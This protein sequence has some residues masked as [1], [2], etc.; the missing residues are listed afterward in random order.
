MIPSPMDVDAINSLASG[1][2][3]I[4]S[5]RWLFQVRWSSFSKKL[6]CSRNP[7]QRQLQKVEQSKAWSKSASKGKNKEGKEDGK[8]K[9][10]KGAKGSH[11]GKTLQTGLS[12]LQNSKSVISSE[13]QE[14]AQTCPIDD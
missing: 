7:T 8:S 9:G 14:S 11:N 13:T 6:Q 2:G 4:E 10:A 3:V 12:G 1:K 5:T